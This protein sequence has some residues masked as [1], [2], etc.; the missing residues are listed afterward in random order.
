[1]NKL[2]QTKNK[3]NETVLLTMAQAEEL[4]KNNKKHISDFKAVK[5]VEFK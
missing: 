2:Y 3:N 1:M 4:I 5:S